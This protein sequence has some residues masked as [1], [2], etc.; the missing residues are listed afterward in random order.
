MDSGL[1][2]DHEGASEDNFMI[3][4]TISPALVAQA[5]MLRSFCL[6]RI[7]SLDFL[8]LFYQEKRT[9]SINN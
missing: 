9:K 6:Q 1:P 8:V 2:S 7:F 5:D 3:D 4:V